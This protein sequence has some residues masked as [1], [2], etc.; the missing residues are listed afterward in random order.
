MCTL[1][2]KQN[3]QS[4]NCG[5]SKLSRNVEPINFGRVSTPWCLWIWNWQ[6]CELTIGSH[7][8]FRPCDS[9]LNWSNWALTMAKIAFLMLPFLD[10][11]ERRPGMILDWKWQGWFVAYHSLSNEGG[12]PTDST[13]TE[14]CIL[15]ISPFPTCVLC[16]RKKH[17]EQKLWKLKTL[18]KCWAHKLWSGL[19]SMVSVDLELAEMW[20]DHWFTWGIQTLWFQAKLIEL[21]LDH[22]QDSLLDVAFLRCTRKEASMILDWK[23]QGWFVAYHSLSNEGG[24][25]TDSTATEPCI[26]SLKYILYF[27]ASWIPGSRVGNEAGELTP[28]FV[29]PCWWEGPAT[30]ALAW[31]L[32]RTDG[33]FVAWDS[34]ICS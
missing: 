17:P 4:K 18:E 6:R 28:R 20:I 16:A 10:A 34:W 27:F 12:S 8:A 14:P 19:N 26:P 21:S 5:N 1:C 22:G 7:E 3:I 15:N 23:W 2:T 13:A 25:P 11:L 33:R 24:S 30:L 29:S 32:A 31:W 9:K